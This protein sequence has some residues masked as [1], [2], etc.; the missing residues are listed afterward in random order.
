MRFYL[1]THRP[2]WLARTTTPLFISRRV[3][4]K[5]R[6]PSARGSWALDSGGFTELSLYG[7]WR[8][9]EAEYLADVRRFRDEIGGMEWAAPM[10]WMCEPW[11]V[12]KTGLSV[13]E[14]QRRTVQNFR[15]L[16]SAAPDLPIIPVLQGWSFD[17]YQTCLTLYRLAGFDLRDEPLVGL[18][19][20]CRRQATGEI[21][22]IA[23]RLSRHGLRLHGFGVKTNGL[24]RYADYLVS[25]DSMA[26]SRQARWEPPIKGHSH[27][28]C[29]NCIVW[30]E[31][32]HHRISMQLN[33][34]QLHLCPR[35]G[36]SR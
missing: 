1:G 24:A 8:T 26:W 36:F 25:A 22:V 17:D 9:T 32:W 20:V 7:A 23:E 18:G 33:T 13:L 4:P 12:E 28:S 10:D 30:A 34:I 14:H 2:S 11:I 29:A 15:R 35:R 31:R 16:R 19:S 5:T 21:E 3:V 27:K 6:L